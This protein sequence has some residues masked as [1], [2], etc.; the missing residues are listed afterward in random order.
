MTSHSANVVTQRD[1]NHQGRLMPEIGRYALPVE[2]DRED[3]QRNCPDEE[4]HRQALEAFRSKAAA[5]YV[6][7][8]HLCD[9]PSLYGFD[10]DELVDS[11]CGYS[12]SG[13]LPGLTTSGMIDPSLPLMMVSA[14]IEKGA[15]KEMLLKESGFQTLQP[16]HPTLLQ[17]LTAEDK[18]SERIAVYLLHYLLKAIG[19]VAAVL[20]KVNGMIIFSDHPGWLRFSEVLLENCSW[21]GFTP[22]KNMLHDQA[23]T[24]LTTSESPHPAFF[25]II[26]K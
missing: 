18:G 4:L 2:I 23:L 22:S 21:M 25:L 8:I 17:M 9:Q 24:K 13:G 19:E 7:S 12:V 1:H 20:T 14:G 6:I 11:T 10:Q 16:F 3:Y 5:R 15:I 26:R